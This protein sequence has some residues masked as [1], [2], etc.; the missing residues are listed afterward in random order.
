MSQIR[1]CPHSFKR[2]LSTLHHNSQDPPAT[3][4]LHSPPLIRITTSLPGGLNPTQ[5]SLLL[6]FPAPELENKV[7]LNVSLFNRVF[8]HVCQVGHQQY[9]TKP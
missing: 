1:R 3:A 5:F 2:T 8:L 9:D 6:L 4:V 7:F